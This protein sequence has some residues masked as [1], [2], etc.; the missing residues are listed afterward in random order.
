MKTTFDLPDLLVRRAKALAARQGRPLRD[1][2][3]EAIDRKLVSEPSEV[4]D[5]SE[6]F[7]GRQK[8]WEAWKARLVQEPDGTWRNPDGIEDESFFETLEHVRREPWPSRDDFDD[9]R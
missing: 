9:A 6:D 5:R 3:A 2:V 7:E 8:S 4:T 1:L